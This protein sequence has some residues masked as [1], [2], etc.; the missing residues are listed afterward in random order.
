MRIAR[1]KVPVI[2]G[3]VGTI[4]AIGRWHQMDLLQG[5]RNNKAHGVEA[6]GRL[7]FIEAFKG[8]GQGG[9]LEREAG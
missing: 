2:S 3:R 4:A 8:S 7:R 1:W 5:R 9:W 6:D